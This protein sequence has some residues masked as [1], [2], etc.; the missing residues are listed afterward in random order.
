[1]KIQKVILIQLVCFAGSLLF[2]QLTTKELLIKKQ[3][4]TLTEEADNN[5]STISPSNQLSVNFL[6][7]LKRHH[8]TSKIQ[9]EEG[10]V[11]LYYGYDLFSLFP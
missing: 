4:K 6:D 9:F 5:R 7:S 2:S 1:M 3:I 11:L 10:D 8:Y